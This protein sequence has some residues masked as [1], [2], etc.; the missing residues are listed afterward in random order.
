MI[1]LQNEYVIGNK[2]GDD[3]ARPMVPEKQQ[4]EPRKGALGLPRS[5]RTCD[6]AAKPRLLL[7]KE[8]PV[9]QVGMAGI[10]VRH[11]THDA[12]PTAVPGPSARRPKR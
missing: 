5:Q 7:G 11:L 9:E 4:G 1:I 6:H 2:C 12:R 10:L 3:G 8:A